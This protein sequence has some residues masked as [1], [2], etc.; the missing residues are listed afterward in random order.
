MKHRVLSVVL[1]LVLLLGMVPLNAFAASNY[2]ASAACVE[3]I[4]SFE[5]FHKYPYEDHGQYTVGYGT[6]CSGEDLE[7]YQ[8][9]GIS[10]EEATQLLKEF[11]NPI[12]SGAPTSFLSLKHDFRQNRIPSLLSGLL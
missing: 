12:H 9:E 6:R 7:R 3:L 2:S 10:K 8:R 5:G 1:A 11:L 4:K